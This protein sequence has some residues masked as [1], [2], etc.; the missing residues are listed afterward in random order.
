M[1]LSQWCRD[2]ALCIGISME[3]DLTAAVDWLASPHRRGGPLDDGLDRE[4]VKAELKRM[5][6][7]LSPAQVAQWA[8]PSVSPLKYTCLQTALRWSYGYKLKQHVRSANVDF[9]APVRSVRLIEHYNTKLRDDSMSEYLPEVANL[10]TCRG[11]KWCMRWRTL[12][13]G[14]VASL[15][16]ME[17]VSLP[18]K[19]KQAPTGGEVGCIVPPSLCLRK[20]GVI[21]PAPL[22]PSLAYPSLPPTLRVD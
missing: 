4:T 1:T 14:K 19:R 17:P 12:H 6:D 20:T 18:D 22:L 16:S 13:G 3:G 5:Y 2:T 9:G 10:E 21:M 7:E 15:R 11:R 8:D